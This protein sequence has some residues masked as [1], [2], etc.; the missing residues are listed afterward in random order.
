MVNE[1]QLQVLRGLKPKLIGAQP[2]AGDVMAAVAALGGHFKRNGFAGWLILGRGWRK[3]LE[4]ERGF[5]LA[6]AT[7]HEM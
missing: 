1:V 4:V 7:L 5:R 2:T 6:M 3:L